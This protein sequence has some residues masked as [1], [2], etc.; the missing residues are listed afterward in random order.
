MGGRPKHRQVLDRYG[1]PRSGDWWYVCARCGAYGYGVEG[2]RYCGHD[3]AQAAASAAH[4]KRSQHAVR[5]RL[6][7]G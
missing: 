2:K 4:R 7:Y 5:N 6:P 3:C 1:L